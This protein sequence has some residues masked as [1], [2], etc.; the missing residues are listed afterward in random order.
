[1]SIIAYTHISFKNIDLFLVTDY[2]FGDKTSEIYRLNP[3]FVDIF[4]IIAHLR[5][6]NLN[7]LYLN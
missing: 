7:E 1:M 5:E 4:N 3:E 6:K 2:C